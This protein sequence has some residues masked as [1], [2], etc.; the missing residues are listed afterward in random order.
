VALATAHCRQVASEDDLS[1]PIAVPLAATL[2]AQYTG[3]DI[4]YHALSVV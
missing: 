4:L 2:A 1:V 3:G